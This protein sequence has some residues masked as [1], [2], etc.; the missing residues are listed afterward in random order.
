LGLYIV[1]KDKLGLKPSEIT[2]LLGIMAF[3]WVLKIFLAITQDNLTCCGSRRKSYM[4]VNASI[5]FLFMILLICFGIMFGVVFI[6]F[7]IVLSQICMTWCDA[8]SDALIAQASR[9][10][11][12][13]GAANLN[14][15]TTYCYALGG[16]IACIGGG[17]IDYSE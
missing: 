6:M 3:P 9:V 13:S 12:K 4:I 11:L 16:A 14:S 10:D 15:F 5:N 17:F 2:L 7:C 8:T 1:F